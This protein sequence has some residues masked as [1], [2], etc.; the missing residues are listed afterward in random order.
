M[1]DGHVYSHVVFTT[2][3]GRPIFLEEAIDAAFKR[4]AHETARDKG[5]AILELE[6]MPNHGHVLIEKA[7]WESLPRVVDDLKGI[8]A[9]RLLQRF[10]WPRGN[11][12][13]YHC[14]NRGSHYVR[15]TDASLATL[16]AYIRH[17]RLAGGLAE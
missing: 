16:R 1:G 4:L 9:R 13:S 8:T 5:W 7:P 15:H 17:Q 10:E 2:T 6:T 12:H 14:W 11:L 3:R